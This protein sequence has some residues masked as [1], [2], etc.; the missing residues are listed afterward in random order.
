MHILQQADN[1]GLP[2]PHLQINLL[3]LHAACGQMHAHV[4]DAAG[5]RD[6][7][8]VGLPVGGGLEGEGEAVGGEEVFVAIE[9][10]GDGGGAGG[11]GFEGEFGGDGTG[12]LELRFRDEGGFVG[13]VGCEDEKAVFGDELAIAG[14]PALRFRRSGGGCCD[15]WSFD[16]AF[17]VV[18]EV[19]VPRR[20]HGAECHAGWCEAV[21]PGFELRAESRG[22]LGVLRGEVV[23]LLAVG[24]EV[25][26]VFAITTAQKFPASFA[27]GAL[28]HPA[29]VERFVRRCFVFAGEMREEI[30][31]IEL[32]GLHGQIRDR[33]RRRGDIERT[34]GMLINLTARDR[35]GPG[36]EKG[37]GH[38]AFGQHAFFA[39]QRGIQAA[40]PAT[41]IALE[42]R[43]D[44]VDL[45]RSAVVADEEDER[46]LGEAVFLQGARDEAHAVVDGRKHGQRGAASLRHLAGKAVHVALGRVQRRV[47]AA[48][49][50]VE[51]EGLVFISLDDRRGGL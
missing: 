37:C 39:V 48:I 46:L 43:I 50:H 2:F 13:L 12:E 25:V 32:A 51:E 33:G 3:K 4:D 9:T 34:H 28:R 27:N 21:G 20:G 36:D 18:I 24:G 26:E 29:P 41:G 30:H 19:V 15:G 31:A 8:G 10:P 6:F 42:R 49:G 40:I 14:F 45:Q 16:F 44:L 35:A 17:E 5:G 22:D 23:L 11:G 38:A 7:E 1:A 47:R